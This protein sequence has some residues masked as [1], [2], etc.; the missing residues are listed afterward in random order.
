MVLYETELT[1]HYQPDHNYNFREDQMAVD[2]FSVLVS[3]VSH[4][5][6]D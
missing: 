1:C 6:Q 4:V 3:A 5:V 2:N